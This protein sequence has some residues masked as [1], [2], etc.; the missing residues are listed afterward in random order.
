VWWFF[1]LV[2]RQHVFDQLFDLI[3]HV[4]EFSG[5]PVNLFPLL[6]DNAIQLIDCVRGVRKIDLK[7]F[8]PTVQFGTHR[9]L[10]ASNNLRSLSSG[11]PNL[12]QTNLLDGGTSLQL[13]TWHSVFREKTEK[14][15]PEPE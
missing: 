5:Q 8:E 15:W 4:E 7:F 9:G 14:S 10:F 13:G 12:R 1:D 3:G 11:I 6:N 2:T